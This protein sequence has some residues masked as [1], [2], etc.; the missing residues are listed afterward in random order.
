MTRTEYFE[1]VVDLLK[2]EMHTFPMNSE[3][4]ERFLPFVN[5]CYSSP[6]EYYGDLM[7]LLKELLASNNYPNNKNRI[8]KLYCEIRDAFNKSGYLSP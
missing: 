8:E 6:T 1:Y 2:Q 7:L 3:F 5:C 4:Y